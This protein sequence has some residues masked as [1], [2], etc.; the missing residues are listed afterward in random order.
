MHAGVFI[1]TPKGVLLCKINAPTG[2]NSFLQELTPTE[3]EGKNENGA[4]P[5]P[6]RVPI[7]L[8]Q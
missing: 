3:K 8:Y 2:A 5:L 1:S 6:E 7:H 4:V